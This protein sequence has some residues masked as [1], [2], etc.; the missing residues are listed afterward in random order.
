MKR[1]FKLLTLLALFSGLLVTS[2]KKDEENPLLGK[3]KYSTMIGGEEVSSRTYEF[4][5]SR[6]TLT[7]SLFGVVAPP[8]TGT[9]SRTSET[10]T[11]FTTPSVTYNYS[12]SEDKSILTLTDKDGS[13]REYIKQ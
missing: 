12:I 7:L 2:C 10:I 5:H 11:F 1:T 3:W 6:Y 4:E 13:S 9:Y 8:E